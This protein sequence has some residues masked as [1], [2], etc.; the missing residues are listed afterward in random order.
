MPV[1]GAASDRYLCYRRCSLAAWSSRGPS[2]RALTRGCKRVCQNPRMETT[3]TPRL[4]QHLWKA[5][6]A[7]GTISV[8]L[9]AA[10]LAWPG[11]TILVASTVFG[12]YLLVTGVSQVVLAL[13]LKVSWGMRVLPFISGVAAMALAVLCFL[14][15]QNSIL[16][17]AIWIGVGF[18]FRGV[19]TT[20]SA[21]GDPALPG[22]MWQVFIGAVSLVAGIVMLGSPFASIAMLTLVVGTWLV[23][24]GAFEVISSFGVRSVLRTQ[25]NA[26]APSTAPRTE[27]DES[28][29]SSTGESKEDQPAVVTE[30]ARATSASGRK[31][32]G[33]REAK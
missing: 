8:V 6:L 30:S 22:R 13:S 25:T 14:S 33:Q 26:V 23:V 27:D 17:L 29:S 24:V 12:A 16:L 9:G 18:V 5:T 2:N 31:I 19:A 4:M 1:A 10:V 7:S 3:V 20:T 11:K 15:L 28:A 32:S 21:L